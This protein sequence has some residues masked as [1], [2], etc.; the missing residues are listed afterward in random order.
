MVAIS[1]ITK[2]RNINKK[3]LNI[4]AGMEFFSYMKLFK[5]VKPEVYFCFKFLLINIL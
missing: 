2:E 1:D 3:Y 5:A 4:F